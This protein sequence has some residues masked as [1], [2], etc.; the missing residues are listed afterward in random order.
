M[1]PRP[2][3]ERVVRAS[4]LTHVRIPR[5]LGTMDDRFINRELSWLA[6]NDRVL[7]ARQRAGHPAARAGEVLRHLLVQPRRVLPGPRRRAEGPGRR[8]RSRSRRPTGAP[9]A[10]Q[11]AEITERAGELVAAPGGRVPR[12]AG[13]RAGRSR[14][15]PSSA[16]TTSTTPTASGCR[17]IY[18]QRI[19]PVL[20]PLA[21]DPSHPFPY[22]SNLALSSPRWSST[23]TTATT[24]ASP[25]SR[26]RPCSRAWSSSTTA[27]F[28]PV[29]QLIIAQPAHA[30][31]R[32]GGRGVRRSFRVTR[33]ADLTLE[34]EEADDLLEAVEMELRRR[35][36]NRAVR[37]EV[38][39]SDQRRD[40]RAARARARAPPGRRLPPTAARST[41]AACGSCTPSIAPIS[42][43]GRGRRS[44]P[45]ASPWPRRPSDRSSR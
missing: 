29:E 26:C 22:I 23:P 31:R 38:A 16:G 10:Q 20:T 14:A 43:T 13:A 35:R 27:R 9:P 45:G 2:P 18:E 40:A 5:Q 17:E 39:E 21:V 6:F 24:G 34:D 8:R 25:G 12:R 37:L 11:L 3:D 28:L 36:F 42:R 32:H 44:R 19:F 41:S 4:Q 1:G 7:A 33:N 15:S 30:V